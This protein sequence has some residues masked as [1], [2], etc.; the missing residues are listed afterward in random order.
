LAKAIY[1]TSGRYVAFILNDVIYKANGAYAGVVI[2]DAV[3]NRRGKYVGQLWQHYVVD[4]GYRFAS[5]AAPSYGSMAG[6]S[7][8]DVAGVASSYPDATDALLKD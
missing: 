8:A 1:T 4:M 7:Y 6:M 3:Y 5:I 2:N